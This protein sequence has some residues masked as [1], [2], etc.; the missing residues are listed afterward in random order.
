MQ[1]RSAASVNRN[2][3]FVGSIPWSV[4]LN[5][6]GTN[7]LPMFSQSKVRNCAVPPDDLRSD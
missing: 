6:N 5:G 1:A 2:A 7:W 3:K 4:A